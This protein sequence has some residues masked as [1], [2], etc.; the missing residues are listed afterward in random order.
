[1]T[2]AILTQ[3]LTDAVVR[4]LARY[5]EH[6]DELDV[7]IYLARADGIPNTSVQTRCREIGRPQ[8]LRAIREA[9]ARVEARVE[10]AVEDYLRG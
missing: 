5:A 4:T 6:E 8:T 3:E 7:A 10:A 2:P 9:E 1:M